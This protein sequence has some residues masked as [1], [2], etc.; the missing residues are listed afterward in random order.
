MK[1]CIAALDKAF[2]KLQD[3][4]EDEIEF[5]IYRSAVI[6]EFEII[7]EQSGKLLKKRLRPFFHSNKAADQL[8][9]K[10]LF[11]HAALHSLLTAE[12]VERWLGYRDNRNST[13]HDYGEELENKTLVL[14]P[15]FLSDAQ[16]LVE[17]IDAA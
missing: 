2:S 14:I 12:E 6:K 13:S 10:D 8:Y 15:Q 1:R 16:K 7:L 5:E 17:V 3:S 4:K 11:R 9:F